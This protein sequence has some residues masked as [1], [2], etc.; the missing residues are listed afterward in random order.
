MFLWL[1]RYAPDYGQVPSPWS[2]PTF[3]QKSELAAVPGVSQ[4]CDLDEFCLGDEVE[5]RK[6]FAL[7]MPQAP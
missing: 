4:R 1:K 5:L 7:M 6:F 2:F 3:W